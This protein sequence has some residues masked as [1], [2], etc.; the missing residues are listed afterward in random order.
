MNDTER[1]VNMGGVWKDGEFVLAS[2][3]EAREKKPAPLSFDALRDLWL[4]RRSIHD[5]DLMLQL[6]DFARAV[7]ARHGIRET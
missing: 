3:L 5:G 2:T 1:V 6:F 4:H 7:E